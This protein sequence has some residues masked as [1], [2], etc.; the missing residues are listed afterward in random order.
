M[1]L[2]SQKPYT[3]LSGELSWTTEN[4]DWRFSVWGQNLLNKAVVQQMRVGTLQH[5]RHL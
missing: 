2:L 3:M 5:R 1:N 4:G